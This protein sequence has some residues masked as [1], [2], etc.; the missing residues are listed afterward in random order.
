MDAGLLADLGDVWAEVEGNYPPGIKESLTIDGVTYAFPFNVGYWVWYYSKAVYDKY[1][2]E[3]P[4]TW[5][6]FMDQLAFF[7]SK[8]ISGVGNTV[9]KSR[10]TSFIVPMELLYRIDA[11]FYED[12]MNGKAHY[13][14][15][16]AVKMME[17]WKDMLEK[18]YFAPLD[19]TYVEDL[20]RM[21]KEGSLAFAPFG[22]WYSGLMQGQGLVPGEDYGVFIPPAITSKG[23]GSIILEVS[24]LCSG[25]NSDELAI[26]KDWFKWYAS[27]AG[28]RILWDEL[29]WVNPVF[30]SAEEIA[31]GD[32]TLARVLELVKTKYPRKIIRFWE[33]TPVEIVEHAVDA[34]NTMLVHPEQYMDLLKSIEEKAKETWPKYGVSY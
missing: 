10:W 18:G 29:K 23:E 24:P 4:E 6:D 7:K 9:G 14:D 13:T 26:A 32:P 33:A 1:D 15:P 31:E 16:T 12:L 22:D 21:I 25:K 11:D 5:D 30:I 3:P 2:L 20:P 19:A 34:F 8:G 28:A 27:E 17:I